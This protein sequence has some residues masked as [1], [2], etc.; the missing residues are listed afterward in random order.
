MSKSGFSCKTINLF[1]RVAVKI[2]EEE[3][4]P[5]GAGVE[6]RPVG[7]MHYHPVTADVLHRGTEPVA[8]ISRPQGITA[9]P[10]AQIICGFQKLIDRKST[11][12]NSSHRCISYA[13]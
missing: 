9:D 7:S 13:V 11:R 4:D 6:I 5:A 10:C 8:I 12:L 1:I 3:R 2:G